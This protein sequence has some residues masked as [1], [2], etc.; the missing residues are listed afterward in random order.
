M[1]KMGC[2][3]ADVTPDFPVFLRGY[4]FRNKK[5]SAV[6]DRLETGV[7][8]LEQ[9][10]RKILLITADMEGIF[11]E[12]CR[13]ITARIRREFGIGYPDV[14][15]SCSHT[16]FSPGFPGYAV[17]FP[18]GEIPLGI[19]PRDEQYFEFWYERTR[20]AVRRALEDLE[21]VRLDH[22]AVPV[23]G[24]AFNR[25]TVRKADGKVETNYVLPDHPGDYDFLPID[26]DF[27][28]WRFMKG[29]RPKA[30]L[31]RYSCHPVTGDALQ[32]DISADYPGAFK[33]AVQT[34][35]GCPGFFLLGTAGD[36][37]PMKR[38]AR[39]RKYMGGI[40]ARMIHVNEL[41]FSPAPEFRLEARSFT[42]R[43]TIVHRLGSGD[44]DAFWQDV[45]R[46]AQKSIVYGNTPDK[47]ATYQKLWDAGYRYLLT[48][49]FAANE[50]DIPIQMLRLGDRI[51]VGL[52]FEIL[53]D[54]GRKLREACPDALI[55][56]ITG[57][58]EGYLPLAS[59]YEIGGYET[60]TEAHFQPDTG[61]RILAECIK[62]V[63]SFRN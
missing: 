13:E 35:Y 3:Q 31:G 53:T 17:T 52:P 58:Y 5:T 56:S 54:V 50:F 40:L 36:V 42:V 4:G 47:N 57:G 46:D 27:T 39:A 37:V 7:I 23:P 33:Q 59:D 24:I 18:G 10:G 62:A 8:A 2:A 25:R 14:V 30:I 55:I 1:L 21:E 11:V 41:N 48:K 29:D 26:H 32:Y 44:P 51:L 16:H 20:D 15:I 60:E 38:S 22:A 19:Y 28:V 12:Y 43:S 61:D 34:E 49:R 6:A 9:S 63:R 45:L